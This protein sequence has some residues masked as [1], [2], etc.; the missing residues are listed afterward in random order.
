M[1]IV[2]ARVKIFS[3]ILTLVLFSLPCATAFAQPA[4]DSRLAVV[5]SVINDAIAQQQIPGAVLIVGHDGQVVYRK[6]YGSRAH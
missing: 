1:C 5:D 3:T 6:V 2:T 4:L